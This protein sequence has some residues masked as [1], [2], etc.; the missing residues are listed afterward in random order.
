MAAYKMIES[1]E[2]VVN[3]FLHLGTEEMPHEA[4]L[5]AYYDLCTQ[6]IIASIETTN[7]LV[8]K[9]DYD[10]TIDAFQQEIGKL[11][12]RIEQLQQKAEDAAMLFADA[13]FK[14]SEV[15]CRFCNKLAT[16][17]QDVVNRLKEWQEN[18]LT[19]EEMNAC[20]MLRYQTISDEHLVRIYDN[21]VRFGWISNS[22]SLN[23]FAYYFTGKGF[24]PRKRIIWNE[25]EEALCLFL[26][27]ITLDEK[28]LQKA[29]LIFVKRG[30]EDFSTPQLIRV[31]SR[32]KGARI[33]ARRYKL[34][35][36]YYNIFNYEDWYQRAY[37][38]DPPK[39]M[40]D[41]QYLIRR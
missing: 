1:L 11:Q 2:G 35:I 26:E 32:L 34:A 18:A 12:S 41:I 25:G 14:D 24:R 37:R 5:N 8:L 36:I 13:N 31:R 10:I 3:G 40:P 27:S 16:F 30:N 33:D 4:E 20:T 21:L 17:I 38:Q 9:Q 29:P 7:E 22:I 39:G 6:G 19:N 28:D 23:D 15:V